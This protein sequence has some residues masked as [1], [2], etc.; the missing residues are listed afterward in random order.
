MTATADTHGHE[1]VAQE[2]VTQKAVTQSDGSHLLKGNVLTQ[3][4]R[5]C[6]LTSDVDAFAPEAPSTP[7]FS[8]GAEARGDVSHTFL[9]GSV[10]GWACH[11]SR[12]RDTAQ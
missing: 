9:R 3:G 5:P 10:S 2:A 4:E 11:W 12:R 7:S 6:P 1:Q 8:A